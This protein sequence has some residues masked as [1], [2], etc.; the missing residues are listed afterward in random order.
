MQ[1]KST[2]EAQI[3]TKAIEVF[4]FNPQNSTPDIANLV[5]AAKAKQIPVV[6]FTE[7]LVGATFIDWQVTQLQRLADALGP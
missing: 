6:E 4:V 7:T 1:D 5:D 2:V 3:A